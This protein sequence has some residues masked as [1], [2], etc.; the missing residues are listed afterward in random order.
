MSLISNILRSQTKWDKIDFI[1][2]RILFIDIQKDN[3]TISIEKYMVSDNINVSTINVVKIKTKYEQK[4]W[5]KY[6]QKWW[7]KGF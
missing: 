7:D 4:W 1:I 2:K 3:R 6:E 5:D